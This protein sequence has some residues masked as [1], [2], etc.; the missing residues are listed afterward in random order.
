LVQLAQAA[1]MA[2]ILLDAE[3]ENTRM[4]L[5]TTNRKMQ[6]ALARITSKM[7]NRRSAHTRRQSRSCDFGTSPLAM[8][9]PPA[10]PPG[11]SSEVEYVKREP[12]CTGET[13]MAKNERR[14]ARMPATKFPKLRKKMQKETIQGRQVKKK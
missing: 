3:G 2:V 4:H 10:V 9:S 11:N 6:A 13:A 12:R 1:G 8:T 5:P 7:P 14:T